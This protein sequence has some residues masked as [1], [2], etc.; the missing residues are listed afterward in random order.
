MVPIDLIVIQVG[1]PAI[2]KY[3]EPKQTIKNLFIRWMVFNTRKLRL[4]SF[5]FGTRI[6]SEEG[7]LVHH[8]WCA[9]ITRAK[10]TH[11]PAVG[12]IEDVLGP[13]VSFLWEGQLL[14][15]PRHDSVPIIDHRRM[16]V[17]VDVT[18][19]EPIDETERILGHPA[20]SALGGDEVN[21]TIVYSPPHFKQRLIIFV[22]F[23]WLSTSVGFCAMTILPVILGRYIF[24]Q[25]FHVE[26]EVH[27]IY[28]FVLGG[29]TF[30]LT[31]AFIYQFCKLVKEVWSQRTLENSLFVL[32]HRVKQWI[33]WGLRWTWFISAFGV[34]LPIAFG[35]LIELYFVL[36]LRQL[37]Q[38]SPTVQVMPMWSHGFACMVIL[39]GFIQIAPDAT[40]RDTINEVFRGGIGEM[41]VKASFTKLLGPLL[42]VSGIAVC[43]PFIIAFINMNIVGKPCCTAMI[44][45]AA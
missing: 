35:I 26:N 30:L 6:P 32:Y 10:P 2:V 3:F 25:Q 11:Y 13:E 42:L 38:D 9:W 16:L 27:D 44:F 31:G 20:S 18:T 7:R 36:P 28:S 12:S 5:I 19:L 23:M 24:E 22:G 1:I 37:G 45:S 4:S 29:S 43:L 39:H 40:A 41:N 34:V 17:P 8:T 33:F 21:T 15:V 14:R